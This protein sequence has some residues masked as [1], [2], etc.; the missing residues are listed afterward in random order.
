MQVLTKTGLVNSTLVGL[1]RYKKPV[2][3]K[4]GWLASLLLLVI[5]QPSRSGV[6]ATLFR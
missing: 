2:I 6:L 4:K 1:N 5:T 3:Q